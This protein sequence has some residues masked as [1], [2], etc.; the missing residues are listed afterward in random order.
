MDSRA[1]AALGLSTLVVTS[2]AI[3]IVFVALTADV[4]PVSAQPGEDIGWTVTI[5]ADWNSG[6]YENTWNDGGV[7]KLGERVVENVFRQHVLDMRPYP[8]PPFIEKPTEYTSRLSLAEL[9][10]VRL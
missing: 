9:W 4:P 1:K 5:A 6:T 2:F 8:F 7:L 3:P 10:M